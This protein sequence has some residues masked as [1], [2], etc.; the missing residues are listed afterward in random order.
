M[1]SNLFPADFYEYD[2]RLGGMTATGTASEDPHVEMWAILTKKRVDVVAW[3]GSTPW[4]VEVKPVASFSALGQCLGYGFMW[5][6]EKP[7][8]VKPRLACVCAVCDRDLK[9]CFSSYGVSVLE[10]PPSVAEVLLTPKGQ[11]PPDTTI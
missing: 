1:A 8:L 4:L 7:G 2:I 9:P 3:R 11:H 6:K 10:L 5:A